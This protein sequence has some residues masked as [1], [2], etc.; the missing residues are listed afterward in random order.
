MSATALDMEPSMLAYASQLARE[1]GV[2]GIH[3]IQGDMR[4]FRLGEKVRGARGRST[5]QRHRQSACQFIQHQG[6]KSI[7]SV[8]AAERATTC[9]AG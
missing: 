1:E 7:V 4:D 9:H 6:H 2:D 5:V 3:F 8:N